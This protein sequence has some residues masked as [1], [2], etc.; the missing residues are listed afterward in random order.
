MGPER[1]NILDIKLSRDGKKRNLYELIG[2]DNLSI[3]KL[4]RNYPKLKNIKTRV[5]HQLIIESRY[6]IHIKKQI[7]SLKAYKKDLNIKIPSKINYK[8]VGGLSKECCLALEKVRPTNLASASRI[9]GITP[10]ALT[11][12]LLYTKKARQKIA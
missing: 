3:E 5:L 6:D 7:E 11:S 8:K 12:V 2:F 4:K 10:A 9:P 1:A